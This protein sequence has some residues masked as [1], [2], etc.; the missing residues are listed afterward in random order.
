MTCAGTLVGTA[1]MIGSGVSAISGCVG[2]GLGAADA[3]GA[4]VGLGAAVGANFASSWCT[5]G[6]GGA[7][8]GCAATMRGATGACGCG[9]AACGTAIATVF[10]TAWLVT[11]T[12]CAPWIDSEDDCSEDEVASEKSSSANRACTKSDRTK[13]V[14]SRAE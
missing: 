10:G 5:G 7:E 13:L 1:A 6:C 14:D 4:G 9:G 12:I 8:R 11:V 3:S 2:C